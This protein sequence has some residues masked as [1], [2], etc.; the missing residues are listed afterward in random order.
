MRLSSVLCK[1]KNWSNHYSNLPE[2]Y[3][4]RASEQI[5]W[6]NP[7]GP[8]YKPDAVVKRK[9]FNYSENRPW[10]LQFQQDNA[11]GST[12]SKVWVEPVKEWSYFR[13][14]RVEILEGKDK[15]KQGFVSCIIQE[16]NW[17]L[18]EG[19]NCKLEK[20]GKMRH[21]IMKYSIR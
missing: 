20:L 4:K 18:V 13:G 2:S 12:V 8:Q 6:K 15:G 1:A 14:D 16:R 17:V 7:K 9:K 5:Y 3:I 10:S 11:R 21:F 19:L